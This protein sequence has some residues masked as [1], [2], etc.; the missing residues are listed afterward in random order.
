MSNVR[1][2]NEY[3]LDEYES[4]KDRDKTEQQIKHRDQVMYWQE[5]APTQLVIQA[6][7]NNMRAMYGEKACQ[8]IVNQLKTLGV[9][10]DKVKCKTDSSKKKKRAA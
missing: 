6:H 9:I 10:D 8:M 7:I 4:N 2:M 5:E 1:Q 3:I